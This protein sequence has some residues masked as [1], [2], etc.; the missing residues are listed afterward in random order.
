M[1]GGVG[2]F[3]PFLSLN[4]LSWQRPLRYRKRKA[5]LISAIQYLP[6]DAKIVKIG[7][8]DP[9]ILQLRVNK[10]ATAQYLVAIRT[11]LD[12]SEN[13][14]QFH[15]R[16]VKRFHM[17]KRLRKSVQYIRRYS[18]KYAEPRRRHTTQFRLESSPPKLLNRSSPKFYTI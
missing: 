8:V 7:P 11:T 16:R 6:Y 9:E 5:R 12:K 3:S 1:H 13:K 4:W 17:V 2:N 14:V 15:D 10:S 18:M